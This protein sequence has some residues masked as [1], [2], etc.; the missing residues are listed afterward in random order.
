ML[1]VT[2]CSRTL[3]FILQVHIHHWAF[4]SDSVLK[5][6]PAN[7]GDTGSVPGSGRHPGRMHGD[8]LT[9]LA[10]RI[11]W[12]DREAWQ[13]TVHRVTKS[14]TWRKR[15]SMQAWMHGST[16]SPPVYLYQIW[17]FG[18]DQNDLQFPNFVLHDFLC[19]THFLCSCHRI[20]LRRVWQKWFLRFEVWQK[21]Q[22]KTKLVNI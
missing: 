21:L 17:Q 18:L 1:K 20:Q 22:K 11:P 3:V 6:P 10:W 15:H 8:L 13:A 16:I 9:L 4:P 2:K 5:N 14:W 19:Q 7:S 12:T